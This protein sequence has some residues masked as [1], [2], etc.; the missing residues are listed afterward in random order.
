MI[1]RKQSLSLEST[2]ADPLVQHCQLRHPTGPFPALAGEAVYRLEPTGSPVWTGYPSRNELPGSH[3][4][5]SFLAS[6]TIVYWRIKKLS[7]DNS[8][9]TLTQGFW[10]LDSGH[11]NW[12]MNISRYGSTHKME[13]SSLIHKVHF[14][15]FEDHL[16]ER[17]YWKTTLVPHDRF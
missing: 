3:C 16:Y 10:N 1:W 8:S 9:E 7:T 14:D 5:L 15:L 11:S 6:L 2:R 12:V 17:D 13:S 4:G